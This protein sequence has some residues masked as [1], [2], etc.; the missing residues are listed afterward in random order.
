VFHSDEEISYLIKEIWKWYDFFHSVRDVF[1]L[2]E[3]DSCVL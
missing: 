1:L 2:C 3:S